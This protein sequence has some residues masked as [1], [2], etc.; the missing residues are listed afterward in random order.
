MAKHVN[1]HE[2]HYGPYG[3]VCMYTGQFDSGECWV[4]QAKTRQISTE[5]ATQLI[6]ERKTCT[7]KYEYL[8]NY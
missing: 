5:E 6:H 7:G 1:Q 4:C 2:E 8:K 3:A